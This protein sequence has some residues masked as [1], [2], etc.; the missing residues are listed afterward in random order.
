MSEMRGL[1]SDL[2][3]I[4]RDLRVL[5][6]RVQ[7]AKH[8]G[9]FLASVYDDIQGIRRELR[10]ISD[11]LSSVAEAI[12]R[13]EPVAKAVKAAYKAASEL[14]W[15]I[16]SYSGGDPNMVLGGEV[17]EKLDEL[18][19][20]VVELTGH[21]CRYRA[22]NRLSSALN[23][24]ASCIHRVAESLLESVKKAG[25]CEITKDADPDAVAACATWSAATDMLESSGLYNP[26]DAEA[27][28]GYVSG[29][30][31]YLRV[32]SSEGHRTHLD[33][34]QGK[35]RYYDYDDDVNRVMKNLLSDVAHLDCQVLEDGVECRG[36]TK[37][38]AAEAAATLAFA[39]SMDFRLRSPIDYWNLSNLEE[40][41]VKGKLGEILDAVREEARKILRGLGL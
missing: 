3:K 7:L 13:M 2:L 11:N 1:S 25:K 16:P 41:M 10:D 40:N 5:A 17:E 4:E 21:K 28:W 24:L 31:V 32:G 34:E 12:P 14:E 9:E 19:K 29:K 27:L 36:L 22:S 39:T 33:L 23:D 30:H 6:T 26:G 18:E 37:G 8:D 20:R 15:A 35:L 38:K